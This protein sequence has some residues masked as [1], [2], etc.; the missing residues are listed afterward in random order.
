MLVAAVLIVVVVKMKI[1]RKKLKQ[2]IREEY[3]RILKE[4]PADPKV[5]EI[6]DLVQAELDAGKGDIFT[7]ADNFWNI[8]F[9]FRNISGMGTTIFKHYRIFYC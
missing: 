9:Y 5:Q 6:A 1:S 4:A 8:I 2:I 7:M 3:A